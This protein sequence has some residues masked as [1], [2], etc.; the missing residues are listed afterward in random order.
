MIKKVVIDRSKWRR[1]G[2]KQENA[3]E[4]CLLN[5]QGFMCCLGFISLVEGFT[6][7]EIFN[8]GEPSD[9]SIKWDAEAR[10]KAENLLEFE[11]DD[12]DDENPFILSSDIVEKAIRI[13]DD[14]GYA[15][16]DLLREQRLKGLFKGIYDLEFVD[17]EANEAT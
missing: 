4:T 2:D 15:P 3:G 12:Q 16:N 10:Q 6:E 11:L 1:G 17:G 13:N 9:M 8:A 14:E 7:E 5:P